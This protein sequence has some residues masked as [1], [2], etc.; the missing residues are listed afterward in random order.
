M[1][2]GGRVQMEIKV[3]LSTATM[4]DAGVDFEI[5]DWNV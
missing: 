5:F 4:Q 1:S 2:Q 3:L